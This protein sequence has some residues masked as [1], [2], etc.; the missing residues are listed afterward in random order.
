M[1][2]YKENKDRVLEYQK[3]YNIVN[4]DTIKQYQKEYY[5]KNK[6]I[7]RNRRN[8]YITKTKKKVI[9]KPYVPLPK[10]KL[11]AIERVIKKKLRDYYDTLYQLKVAKKMIVDE[12]NGSGQTPLTGFK[13]QGGLFTLYFD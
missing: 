3:Y 7:I 1:S 4:I 2:Y 12:V 9:E 10:Y 8:E 11:D 13:M 5:Q 6:D